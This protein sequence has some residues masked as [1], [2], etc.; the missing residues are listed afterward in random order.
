MLESVGLVGSRAG[1]AALARA[2]PRRRSRRRRRG[3]RTGAVVLDLRTVDP[4]DDVALCR[5]SREP[6]RG[7]A[8]AG[9]GGPDDRRHR[10]RRPHRPR[11]DDAAAGADRD[12]RGPLP[13]ERRRGMT[14]DVGYAHLTLPGRHRARLR[15][16]PGPRPA[17][18]QH[19][20]RRR[21]DRCGD[22]R[23]GGRRRPARPDD[24]APRAARC[25]RDQARGGGGDQ[26]R[27]RRAERTA[28]V[29]GRSAAPRRNDPCGIAGPRRVVG[30]W[31][32][33]RGVARR[34]RGGLARV[35]S[36]V[37][38]GADRGRRTG[39]ASRSTASSRSRAAARS[40]PGRFA[41]AP[42]ARGATLRLVPGD[43]R[44]RSARSRST[45]S[46]WTRARANR[47][48]TWPASRSRTWPRSGSHR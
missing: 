42:L 16:R 37:R 22:A 18:R 24:R 33:D 48:S 45:A 10:D 34:A 13:E 3:S 27:C 41:A 6:S 39:S 9:G 7:R 14:I 23:R 2:A 28:E 47:H 36:T 44:A 43:R 4:A 32:R 17:G 26:G 38:P 12:R 29:V 30:R 46:R 15:R 5:R 11:Q 1:A 40:S 19:A 21:R 20:R 8:A 35:G 25:A 31:R